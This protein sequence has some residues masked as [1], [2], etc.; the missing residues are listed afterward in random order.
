MPIDQAINGFISWKNWKYSIYNG[1]NVP[2]NLYEAS[3]CFQNRDFIVF[4]ERKKFF[5]D[6]KPLP[7]W[8]HQW[9]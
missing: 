3:L 9:S 1:L 5:S 4:M 7:R 8:V 2:L 6:Q